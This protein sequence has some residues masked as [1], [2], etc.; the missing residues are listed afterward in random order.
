MTADPA[1]GEG[2]D[3]GRRRS[4]RSGA[5][6]GADRG[7]V[8][9][10]VAEHHV[11]R[12]F[13]KRK[14][15][16]ADPEALARRGRRDVRVANERPEKFLSALVAPQARSRRGRP[17]R[18]N[19]TPVKRMPAPSPETSRRTTPHR[20]AAPAP[21]FDLEQPAADRI[22]RR[23]EPTSRRSCDPACRRTLTAC[24]AS[25]RLVRRPGDPGFHRAARRTLG[26]S[27]GRMAIPGFGDSTPISMSGAWS[28][29]FSVKL[30]ARTLNLS[31]RLIAWRI[32]ACATNR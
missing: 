3:R 16:R 8:A 10:F 28:P 21:E 20:T 19:P 31:L 11:E 6:A 27:P 22:D 1:E 32:A 17:S 5:D 26:I 23:A 2:N 7:A 9:A 4:G 30:H 15:D 12:Q 13:F 14:R 29:S 25:P 18:Q 24:G